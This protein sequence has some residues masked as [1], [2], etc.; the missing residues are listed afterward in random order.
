MY[1]MVVFSSLLLAIDDCDGD[2]YTGKRV[3]YD[4]SWRLWR[5]NFKTT[6]KHQEEEEEDTTKMITRR[7]HEEEDEDDTKKMQRR[8]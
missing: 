4:I 5:V 7:R 3:I 2:L 1:S 6:A 8:R